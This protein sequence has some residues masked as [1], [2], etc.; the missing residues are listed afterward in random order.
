[1]EE[2]VDENSTNSA[3]KIKHLVISG[4]GLNGFCYYG[5]LRDSNMNGVWDIND[6]ETIY[7]CSIG[8]MLA[9][10]TALRYDWSDIDDYILKRPWEQV[11]ESDLLS[12][13]NSISDKGIYNIRQIE[14][15]ITP[16]L[17]GK[18]L[19]PDITLN[20]F[21][22]TTKIEIHMF[23]TDIH[24]FKSV[25]LSYK[26][27]PDWRV[28]D[29]IYASSAIPVVFA[30]H[31]DGITYYYDGAFF[32]NYPLLNCIENGANPNETLGIA[33]SV[34]QNKRGIIVPDSTM[35]DCMSVVLENIV[36]NI[37]RSAYGGKIGVEYTIEPVST[38]LS[39]SYNAITKKEERA[40][41][42]AIGSE[43]FR[44]AHANLATTETQD[45]N[46]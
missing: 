39:G 27:H 28:V 42:I 6:I 22:Q 20:E 13:L 14:A 41:L 17:L 29:A 4:G 9:A 24:S 25:D 26:T 23:T 18:D 31:T 33:S 1:M 35:F 3:Q 15:I 12:M 38:T 16:L 2:L 44:I 11:F 5:V 40:R 36:H 43:S 45:E 7:G 46:V 30:P 8:S 19:S 34:L 32:T 37:L 21:Y 10:I